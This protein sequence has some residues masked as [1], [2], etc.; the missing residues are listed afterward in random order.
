MYGKSIPRSEL[1]S[2][3]RRH[4]TR[5]SFQAIRRSGSGEDCP[6]CVAGFIYC[7]AAFPAQDPWILT[8]LARVT[9]NAKTITT[10]KTIGGVSTYMHTI[11]T[12]CSLFRYYFRFRW[13]G[14]VVAQSGPRSTVVSW[15]E[16]QVPA[17][18]ACFEPH[19]ASHNAQ[20]NLMPKEKD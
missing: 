4:R 2:E 7:H 19:Y 11:S 16:P 8:A 14:H 15:L 12:E 20:G 10:R 1:R 5:F 18:L 3:Q 17:H 13:S 6:D 9:T